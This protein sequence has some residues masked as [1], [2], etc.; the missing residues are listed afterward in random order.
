M[1]EQIELSS[2]DLHYVDYRLKSKQ[3]EKALL[4]SIIEHGIRDPLQGV[5]RGD[6]ARIL[7]NGFKRYRCAQKLNI[8]IVP[9]SC[10]GNDE[11]CG[12]LKLIRMSNS[13]SLNI[14]E[15]AKLIDELKNVHGMSNGEI[16]DH[17]EKSKSWVSM[18]I[19]IV[20]QM[21]QY[22]MKR[23]FNGDFPV[24]SFMYTL[25]RFI[26]MNSI[27]E[28][29][30]D[31]FVKAVSGKGISIRDID[32]LARGFFKGSDD[33]RQQIKK[34]N[35]AWSLN[36]LKEPVS[37]TAQCTKAEQS[38]LRLLEM[39]HSHMQQLPYRIEDDRLSSA[40]FHAQANILANGILKLMNSFC[41]AMRKFH[42]RCRQA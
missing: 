10:L 11:P 21:S 22:V 24:Y 15:Q 36:R 35:I 41:E 25:R 34:G 33:L 37:K 20:G 3:A 8:S 29:D 28:K 27:T 6:G 16:A 9:Y 2:L 12:I 38:M 13:K 39:L 4:T 14:L 31:E 26:R 42:D 5:D 19:G 7:L 30:I 23:I 1:T 17:L 40:A 32:L 18:R